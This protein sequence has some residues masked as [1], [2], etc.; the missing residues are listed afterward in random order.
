MTKLVQL[1]KVLDWSRAEKDSW[2]SSSD[3]DLLAE[4]VANIEKV[5]DSSDNV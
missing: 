4:I 1:T 5:Y 3:V 2:A